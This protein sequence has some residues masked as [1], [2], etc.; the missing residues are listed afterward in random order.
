MTLHPD[1]ENINDEV[2]RC[3][4]MGLKGVKLHPDFQRF[5]I[6][7]HKAFCIYEAISGRLPL[8]VHTGDF[9]YQW[10]KPERMAKVMDEFPAMTVIGAH[11][12]GWSE[13]DDAARVFKGKN[14]YVDTSST[15]YSVPPEHINELIR[16]VSYTHLLDYTKESTSDN[17]ITVI[18]KNAAGEEVVNTS[19]PA[20]DGIDSGL[21]QIRLIARSAQPYFAN[22]A[23]ETK[24][25]GDVIVNGYQK[26]VDG[27][28]SVNLKNNSNEPK[29]VQVFVAQYEPNGKI[30]KNAKT[31]TAVL[32]GG[33]EQ[34]ITFDGLLQ[35]GAK[36]F[37]WDENLNPYC[38][39]FNLTAE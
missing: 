15:M 3:I 20:I 11:F 4:S 36:V 39:V 13:W 35:D 32:D 9:R 38:S 1:F 16:P 10:S 25:A 24:L 2:E 22:M 23:V 33:A 37:V 8:L 14:I 19:M 26:I 5:H 30:I 21:K 12:G 34:T 27:T 6:D 17:F 31:K 28:G 7:D 18:I 29:S